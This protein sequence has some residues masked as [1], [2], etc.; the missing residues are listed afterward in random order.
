MKKYIAI[1]LLGL[2]FLPHN[3]SALAPYFST[4]ITSGIQNSGRHASTAYNTL[5]TLTAGVKYGLTNNIF[6]RNEF[7]YGKSDYTFKNS[8]GG[9]DYEYDT[10]TQIYMGNII[11]EFQPHG[12]SSSIYAGISAGTTNYKMTLKRP[13][14]G[15]GEKYNTFTYGASAGIS[16]NIIAGLYIDLGVRYMTTADAKS[17]GNL[18]TTSSIHYGF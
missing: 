1:I 13:Y 9:I 14:S 4:G 17:D 2:L 16:L 15:S 3:A 18:I 11:A 6:M 8:I 7:E 5:W 12:F 10:N